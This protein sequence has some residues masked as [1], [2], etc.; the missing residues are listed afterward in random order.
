VTLAVQHTARHSRRFARVGNLANIAGRRAR[1]ATAAEARHAVNAVRRVARHVPARVACFEESI[2]A[3]V[4]LALAGRHA[5]WCHGVAGDPLRFHA[6]LAVNGHP[7]QEPPSTSEYTVLLTIRPDHG[8]RKG[9][10]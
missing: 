7:I 5:T 4:T 2:A 10:S 3:A 9:P 8:D 6:W 1:P